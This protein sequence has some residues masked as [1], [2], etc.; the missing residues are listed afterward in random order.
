MARPHDLPLPLQATSPILHHRDD[1]IDDT[2]AMSPILQQPE[3]IHCHVRDNP[4][5]EHR[6]H[7]TRLPGSAREV[8]GER[9]GCRRRVPDDASHGRPAVRLQGV[10]QDVVHVLAL[11]P[12]LSESGI[13]WILHRFRERHVD[14]PTVP[15]GQY[16]D[17]A[18]GQGVA[19]VG[20]VH[21]TGDV[22]AG[23]VRHDHIPPFLRVQPALRGQVDAG[24]V[25]VRWIL[26]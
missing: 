10:V 6:V 8:H 21:R 1:V 22:L 15:V 17:R 11:R 23:H 24:G 18:A 2:R 12:V 14:D 25:P 16:C 9:V 26:E 4:R 3:H 7:P 19:A 20:G 5:I 13:V